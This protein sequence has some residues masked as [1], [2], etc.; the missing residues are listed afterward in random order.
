MKKCFLVLG[1]GVPKNILK[2]ENYNFYLKMVFNKIYNEVLEKNVSKPVIIF[3]G[4]KTDCFKPYKRNESDEMIKLFKVLKNR[5]VVKSKT[6]DWQMVVERTSLSTL[7]NFLESLKL[8]K[9]LNEVNITV[10]CEYTRK[11]RIQRLIKRVFDKKYKVSINSIDFDVSQN[12][13]LGRDFIEKREKGA[14]KE[15]LKAL[16]NKKSLEEYHQ[17]NLEKI[18][19]LRNKSPKNHVKDLKEYW[20]L[21]LKNNK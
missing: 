6:N 17:Q 16:Q 12:R 1:Y 4:G 3:S 7:E 15:E 14:L 19:F 5:Q 11:K 10:F 20:R 13:Y 8:I 9:K 2:D 18:N 21:K